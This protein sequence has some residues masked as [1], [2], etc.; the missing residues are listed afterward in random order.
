MSAVPPVPAGR[1]ISSISA[2]KNDAV[3]CELCG[4]NA[5]IGCD[6][7]NT[8]FYWCARNATDDDVFFRYFRFSVSESESSRSRLSCFVYA[9]ARARPVCSGK[10][11]QHIDWFGI[12]EKICPLLAP[13][14]TAPPV[15][16]S[17]DERLRRN[18]TIKMSQARDGA[19]DSLRFNF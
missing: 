8:T 19:H 13:L 9:L 10:E 3:V 7:C 4:L 14:R 5:S 12:H 6:R 1:F 2:G 18:L 11:H 16:S 17:E 15:V